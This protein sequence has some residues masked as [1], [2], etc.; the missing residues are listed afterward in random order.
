[1]VPL[2]CEPFRP[3][4]AAREPMKAL[5]I[6]YV[7][8]TKCSGS[9]T[10]SCAAD[11]WSMVL[12]IQ[13]LSVEINDPRPTFQHSV[14]DA[15]AHRSLVVRSRKLAGRERGQV[16]SRHALH[17][18]VFRHCNCGRRVQPGYDP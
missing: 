13:R 18:Q 17:P 14:H 2:D 8:S 10:A 4:G 5:G 16:K 15:I 11:R 1:M 12:S 3:E 9:A 6:T 7:E